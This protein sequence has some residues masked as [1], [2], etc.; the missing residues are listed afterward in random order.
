[1]TSQACQVLCGGWSPEFPANGKGLMG[2][3]WD[4]HHHPRPQMVVCFVFAAEG[5]TPVSPAATVG[6]CGQ[7][8]GESPRLAASRNSCASP[9]SYFP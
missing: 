5:P 4:S 9:A 8:A 1:M 2:T 3:W 6:V 7:Q